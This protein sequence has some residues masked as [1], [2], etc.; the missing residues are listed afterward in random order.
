M[1]MSKPWTR[2]RFTSHLWMIFV[3]GLIIVLREFRSVVFVNDPEHVIVP[4]SLLVTS[5][6]M[7]LMLRLSGILHTQAPEILL[8]HN[9]FPNCCYTRPRLGV[10]SVFHYL[11]QLEHTQSR[12]HIHSQLQLFPIN[13][14]FS[15][16]PVPPSNV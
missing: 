5:P 16:D 4:R 7:V 9:T 1:V 11:F 2:S 8:A 15:S 10:D 14:V 13:K 3:E 12:K 6:L